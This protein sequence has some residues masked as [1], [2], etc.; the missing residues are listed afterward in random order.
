MIAR[1]RIDSYSDGRRCPELTGFEENGG[2]WQLDLNH[3]RNFIYNVT[4]VEPTCELSS[5]EIK[6][7]QSRLEGCL[8]T[9]ERTDNC[10]CDQLERYECIDSMSDIHELSRFFRVFVSIQ[11]EGKIEHPI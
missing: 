7:I 8:E 1:F 11:T 6:I 3:Y 5:R 9:Y 4:G 10:V 2:E